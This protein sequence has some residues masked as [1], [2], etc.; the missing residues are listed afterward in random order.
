MKSDVQYDQ[1]GTGKSSLTYRYVDD[2][3]REDFDPPLETDFTKYA[4]IDEKNYLMAVNDSYTEEYFLFNDNS[5]GRSHVILFTISCKGQD[6]EVEFLN[7]LINMAIRI[8]D[9]EDF[10]CIIAI[11]K[12]DLMQYESISYLEDQL[13]YLIEKQQLSNCG[14]V[15]TSAKTGQGVTELFEQATRRYLSYK[16]SLTFHRFTMLDLINTICNKNE[17]K[18]MKLVLGNNSKNCLTV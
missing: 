3:F 12:M 2:T 6:K 7:N 8:K 13:N 4:T 17:K 18:A 15:K 14:I 11:T 9:T 16:R 5:V 10:P 1:G